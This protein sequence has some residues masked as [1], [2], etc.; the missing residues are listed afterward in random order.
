MDP[1]V[2][3]SAGKR[4]KW[5][6]HVKKTMKAHKGKSLKQV[7]RIAKLDYDKVKG[8]G[9]QLS[10]QPLGGGKRRKTRRGTRRH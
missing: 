3:Q 5:L 8:G 10:P 6:A 1:N 7:L 2:D 9:S 4:S